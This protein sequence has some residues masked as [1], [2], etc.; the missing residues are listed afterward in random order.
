MADSIVK[1]IPLSQIVPS[2]HQA[3]KAF[4][5]AG[6]KGLAE[7]MKQEGLLNPVVVRQAGETFELIS[8]E[9]RLRAAKSLGW[10]AIEAKVI[11]V[12]SEAEAAAKGLVENLQ[13]EDLNPIEEA[14]GFKDL[15]GL[16]DSH[17]T[18]DRIADVV[19]K[20]RTYISRSLTL[21]SLPD[22]VKEDVRRRTLERGHAIEL[23]RINNANSQVGMANKTVKGGWSVRDLRVAIDALLNKASSSRATHVVPAEDPFATLWSNLHKDPAVPAKTWEV[24]YHR[25][26]T[27]TFAVH[28]GGEKP[29]E[30]LAA[31]A[32]MIVKGT[33]RNDMRI[34]ECGMRDKDDS[35]NKGPLP[36]SELRIPHSASPSPEALL[37]EI[38]KTMPPEFA[39]Q[40]AKQYAAITA[41]AKKN[42]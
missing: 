13:R 32:E 25:G 40:M 39:A 34:A 36:N 14:E 19:G 26:G 3:R 5:E 8:G 24:K 29:L 42:H 21:L 30:K 17:W 4:D 11:T 1:S 41:K 20:D 18:Q 38:Q 7:S 22:A 35:I 2:K 27:W 37:S 16:N 12:T 28:T 9:R 15:Q 33:G 6:I 31:W 23:L 10:D